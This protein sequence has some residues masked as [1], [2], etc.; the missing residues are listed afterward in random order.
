MLLCAQER[1][2]LSR[3]GLAFFFLLSLCVFRSSHPDIFYGTSPCAKSTKYF[4]YEYFLL[5]SILDLKTVVITKLEFI[6]FFIMSDTMPSAL[7]I[8]P[9]EERPHHNISVK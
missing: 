9:P 2:L 4:G 5:P 1:P 6:E 7:H 3:I 8:F